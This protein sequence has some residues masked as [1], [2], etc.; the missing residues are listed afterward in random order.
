MKIW[1]GI[2]T[3]EYQK[4]RKVYKQIRDHLIS[5]GCVL[6]RDW[7]PGVEKSFAQE[8]G[9]DRGIKDLYN[10]ILN[11]INEADAVIIEY[12]IPNFSTSHQIH[13]ALMRR[14]PTL[15]LRMKGDNPHFADS[16][17]DA[18][19]SEF[20]VV[21]SYNQQNYKQII[22]EFI[23]FSQT[24]GPSK[25]YNLVL[26][27]KH[28]YY[29]NWLANRQQTTRSAALRTCLDQSMAQDGQY[30]DHIADLID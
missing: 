22:N 3:S 27:G 20:L 6:T 16:Y 11:A 17:M 19:K 12:T 24:E 21:K 14:K 9:Q 18:I 26:H 15:V 28:D 13:Y 23:G 10:K 30:Q 25:R 2:T 29:L 8:L 5:S 7:Y 1:Y 4:Y